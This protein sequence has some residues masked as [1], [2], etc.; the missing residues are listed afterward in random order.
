MLQS[1]L[2]PQNCSLTKPVSGP[3]HLRLD[4]QL[5]MRLVMSPLQGTLLVLAKNRRDGDERLRL[6][7]PFLDAS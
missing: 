7:P 4:A 2:I 6:A 3:I 5:R 1:H